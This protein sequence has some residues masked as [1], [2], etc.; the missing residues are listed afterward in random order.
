MPATTAGTELQNNG[1]SVFLK[2]P[3]DACPIRATPPLGWDELTHLHQAA[4]Q[5]GGRF[6]ITILKC[7]RRPEPG[8]ITSSSKFAK[9]LLLQCFSNPL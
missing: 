6:E 7:R 8:F 2:P 1:S 5:C 4:K 3:G 9:G